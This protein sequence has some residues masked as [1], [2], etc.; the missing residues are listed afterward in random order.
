VQSAVAKSQSAPSSAVGRK[1]SRTSKSA[2]LSAYLVTRDDTLWPQI[3]AYIGQQLILKQSDSV[4]ELLAAAPREHPAIILWDARN[5]PDAALILSRLQQHS[6]CFAVVALDDAGGSNGWQVVVNVA[7]PVSPAELTAA[8]EVAHEEVRARLALLGEEGAE[9]PAPAPSVTRA[10]VSKE[11]SAPSE[12]QPTHASHSASRS[13]RFPKT[14]VLIVIGLAIVCIGYVLLQ[15]QDTVSPAPPRAV[16]AAKA[17]A[18]AALPAADERVDLLIES[19]QKA[20]LDRHFIDPAEGSALSL[21]RSVLQLDPGNGEASQGLLRLTEVL[22]ARVRSALDERKFDVALQALETARSIDPNDSRLAAF[23]QRIAALRAELGPAQIQA[24]INAENFDRA[25]QLIEEAARAKSLTSAKLAQLRDDLKARREEFD[26]GNFVKLIDLRLQQDRVIEPRE[27]SAAFYLSQARDAGASAVMLQPQSQEIDK[28]LAQT[29]R[30]AIDQRRFAEADRMLVD[31]RSDGIL[32]ST[33]APLQRDL[34]AAR[35][36]AAGHDQPQAI[37]LAVSRLAQGKVTEPDN[38]SALF[39]VNELRS[40]DP[41]NA[42]LAHI[43]GLVQSQ[44]L[45][46]ARAALDATQIGSAESLLKLAAGLGASSVLD[47]LNQR[48]ALAKASAAASMQDVAES[49]LTR[50][51]AI[52]TSYPTTARRKNIEGWVEL[53]YQVTPQGSVA[54]IKV[55]NANPAGIFDDAATKALA[56]VRYQPVLKD[57]KPIAVTTRIRIAFRLSK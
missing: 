24:A 3:G 18:A 12:P 2:K 56:R 1:S 53:S 49:S 23:D 7:I 8:L 55:S 38:D 47:T 21:Y 41:N 25:S 42:G 35:L 5:Q 20:M 6:A 43:S 32:A 39:Y 11:I 26:V 52:E 37:D 30:A 44:I 19:A 40:S 17:P 28:R 54:Q 29:V 31:L 22:F 36:Q 48:L 10:P 9:A 13:R 27:D 14:P 15:P 51:N 46:Q 45:E 57:G 34:A 4:D 33:L 16:P 50:I